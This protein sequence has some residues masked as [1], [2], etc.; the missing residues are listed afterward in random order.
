MLTLSAHTRKTALGGV[1][2]G[3]VNGLLGSGGGMLAVPALERAGLDARR[4]HAS[5]IAVIL[6]L[7]AMSA[8]LYLSS[9]RVSLTDALPYLPGGVAGAV[10]GALLM[11]RISPVLLHRLFGGFALWAGLRLLLSR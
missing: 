7:S 3:F 9:G 4:A 6:P 2:A 8:A 11:R 5:S 1:A 10:L